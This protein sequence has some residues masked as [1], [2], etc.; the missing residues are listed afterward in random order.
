MKG[1]QVS[2]LTVAYGSRTVLRDLSLTVSP[3]EI[4]AVLGENGCGKTTLLRAIGGHV[5]PMTGTLTVNDQDLTS[6]SIRRR[7]ALVTLMA[8]ESAAQAGL[9]GMDRIRLG[10]YPAKGLFGRLT[11]AEEEEIA[12]MARSFGILPLLDRDLSEMSTGERQLILLLSASVHRTP[13]LLLDE[14]TASLDFN[15]TEELFLL[16]HRI[17]AQGTAIL[18]VLHDPTQALRHADALVRLTRG[19]AEYWNLRTPD[20]ESLELALRAGYPHLRIHRD[21]LFCYTEAPPTFIDSSERDTT[22]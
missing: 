18:T 21:P 10:F 1:L 8:Q 16:L 22:C 9:T 2:H 15:R 4:V 12:A 13:V 20:Y 14:P 3:G 17:A 11:Q 6:L 19:K 5:S 7:A